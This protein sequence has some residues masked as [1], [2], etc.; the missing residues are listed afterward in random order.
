MS[1]TPTPEHRAWLRANEIQRLQALRNMC[2]ERGLSL[3]EKDRAHTQRVLS[4]I[5]GLLT[6]YKVRPAQGE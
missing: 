3:S 6:K 5:D 1:H 2:M 4:R